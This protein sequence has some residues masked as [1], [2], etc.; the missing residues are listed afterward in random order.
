MVKAVTTTSNAKKAGTGKSGGAAVTRT[1]PVSRPPSQIHGK[2][3]KPKPQP[4]AVRGEPSSETTST[5]RP[6]GCDIVFRTP[7]AVN[8]DD[9][10]KN[11]LNPRNHMG[12]DWSAYVG[13]ERGAQNWVN[14]GEY[15]DHYIRY[16]TDPRFKGEFTHYLRP[17][18]GKDGHIYWE[19]NIP[20]EMIPRFNE[21]TLNRKR[22]Y[23]SA[24]RSQAKC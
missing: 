21:L 22:C 8:A 9:E 15:A 12:G 6:K 3:Y 10:L 16:D 11:G 1:K 2:V 14:G 4:I 20:L 24:S 5:R 17:Y 23:Y 19:Y 18:D 7:K 13:S